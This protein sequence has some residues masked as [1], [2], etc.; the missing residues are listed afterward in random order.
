MGYVN[1]FR[2]ILDVFLVNYTIEINYVY[3]KKKTN[4]QNIQ[5]TQKTLKYKG[6]INNLKLEKKFETIIV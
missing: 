4:C 2:I 6:L 3:V 5:V 1:M